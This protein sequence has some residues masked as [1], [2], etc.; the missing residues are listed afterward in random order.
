MKKNKKGSVININNEKLDFI[1]NI[2]RV[3]NGYCK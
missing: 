2:K 1:I 3:L